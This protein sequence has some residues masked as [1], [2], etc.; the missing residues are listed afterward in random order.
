VSLSRN[1]SYNLVGAMVPLL[2][3]LVTV[4]L[5][6]HLVGIERYGVLQIAWLLLGY[7]GLFDL[8]LG[9]ATAFRIAAQHEASPSARAETFWSALVI[10]IAMGLVGGALLWGAADYAFIDH[11]KVH[12]QLRAEMQISVP[13]L[14]LSVPIATVTGVLTGALQGRE[15]F[16]TTNAVSVTST[17]LFQ[18]LPLFV[19]ATR[20]PYLPALLGGALAA[21]FLGVAILGGYCWLELCQGQRLRARVTTMRTLL[22]YGGWVT[23]TAIFGPMLVI[24]DRFA[25]SAMLGMATVAVYSIPYNLASRIAVL[26]ASLT[27]ALFPRLS[28]ATAEDA[29]EMGADA[30]RVL[31]CIVTPPIMCAILGA[32][33]FLQFW[34]GAKLGFAA[35]PVARLL[36]F[37]FWFNALAL[38]AFTRLQAKGRPD[39]VTKILLVQI[40]PYWAA[41]YFG[42]TRFGLIG[43][44]L[45]FL[46]RMMLDFMMQSW[47]A[48]GR[49]LRWPQVM[50]DGGMLLIALVWAQFLIARPLVYWPGAVG[51][52]TLSVIVGWRDMPLLV[53]RRL[54]NGRS[55]RDTVFA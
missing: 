48:D 20:G 14:A 34:V 15:R 19:A 17:A 40:P 10:N 25:M 38:V 53:R 21:R 8:G 52:M 28:A 39:L 50:R 37:A 45:A 30:T 31:L 4:P 54:T 47:V 35:A 49:I 22:G 1:T 24:V 41:L 36:V 27:N 13:L 55:R 32:Q 42:M 7:F 29:R 51:L 26:P 23:L 43:C 16:L 2:L 11:A 18:L 3:S 6:L 46:S 9:R 5:Y 33:A 12:A 44:A